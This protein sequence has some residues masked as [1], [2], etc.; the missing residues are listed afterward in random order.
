MPDFNKNSL[1]EIVKIIK[2]KKASSLEITNHFIK[3][4]ENQTIERYYN[5][6]IQSNGLKKYRH[7]HLGVWT[8]DLKKLLKML[9]EELDNA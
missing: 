3:N 1:S 7:I 2:T 9:T 6:Y 4:I 5:D 8:I